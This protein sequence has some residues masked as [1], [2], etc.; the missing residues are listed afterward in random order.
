MTSAATTTTAVTIIPP[1][2]T[3]RIVHQTGLHFLEIAL[4]RKLFVD[5]N[6]LFLGQRFGLFSGKA[7]LDQ[8]LAK[9]Q[10][11]ES[12]PVIVCLAQ[13]IQERSA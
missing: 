4:G 5:Q 7:R 11:V 6:G 1:M 13:G 8:S 9:F 10:G 12:D 3:V 2:R